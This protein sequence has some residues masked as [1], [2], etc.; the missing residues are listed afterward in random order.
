MPNIKANEKHLRQSIRR[1]A[2]NKAV[3]TNVKTAV[4]KALEAT[5][6]AKPEA[7]QRVS[8]AIRTIDKATS[9]GI[10]HKNTAA[11]KK[12]RLIAQLRRAPSQPTQP[13]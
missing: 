8:E 2:R 9:K 1:K 4:K 6:S 11:R 12:S 7:G 5:T 3:R 13:A 10:F